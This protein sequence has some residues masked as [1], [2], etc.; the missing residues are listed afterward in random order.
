[1]LL[2]FTASIFD[3]LFIFIVSNSGPVDCDEANTTYWTSDFAID[4]I[5]VH[6]NPKMEFRLR[7]TRSMSS[8][9][10]KNYLNSVFPIAS[11]GESGWIIGHDRLKDPAR[12]C[13]EFVCASSRA[14]LTG[15]S[16][17]RDLD[18]ASRNSNRRP[19]SDS[20]VAKL[21]RVTQ[22]RRC[23]CQCKLAIT[24]NPFSHE[25]DF[26]I[27]RNHLTHRN[28]LNQHPPGDPK[29]TPVIRSLSTTAIDKY[30]GM[31]S[32]L[33][34]QPS[35]VARL[36]ST[37]LGGTVDP[38]AIGRASRSHRSSET[39][40]V[41]EQAVRAIQAEFKKTGDTRNPES[42]L[43]FGFYGDS[44]VS[45][46]IQELRAMTLLDGLRW[47]V[48]LD[49]PSL[50]DLTKLHSLSLTHT[51][52]SPTHVYSSR[53]PMSSENQRVAHQDIPPHFSRNEDPLLAVASHLANASVRHTCPSK[54]ALHNRIIAL[55]HAILHLE[56]KTNQRIDQHCTMVNG[57]IKDITQ[58]LSRMTDTVHGMFAAL[59][60]ANPS[61]PAILG[62]ANPS[63]PTISQHQ[64]AELSKQIKLGLTDLIAELGLRGPASASA[65]NNQSRPSPSSSAS[66]AAQAS[67]QLGTHAPG[68]PSE[69]NPAASQPAISSSQASVQLAMGAP[70]ES[71]QSRLQASSASPAPPASAPPLEPADEEDKIVAL[72]FYDD[73][74]HQF[75]RD[76]S[77]SSIKG[78]LYHVVSLW[79]FGDRQSVPRIR[80]YKLISPQSDLKT[81]SE[82][83]SFSKLSVLMKMVD[84]FLLSKLNITSLNLMQYG[85]EQTT[86]A[87]RFAVDQV[88]IKA[89]QVPD[90]SSLKP[91][92]AS[93]TFTSIYNRMRQKR[94]RPAAEDSLDQEAH[95]DEPGARSDDGIESTHSN[96]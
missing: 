29:S 19:R 79:H 78:D 3:V 93:L 75:P 22:S 33:H 87:V 60:P 24:Q 4:G 89:F 86:Q 21:R 74:W 95:L 71:N 46:L 50:S 94:S 52:S 83:A 15:E 68:A 25:G 65:S 26:Y 61:A 7:G 23:G 58:S 9:E 47:I 88:L 48:D 51:S 67:A 45:L 73:S 35:A 10:L 85:T 63:V 49:A 39:A 91:G 53:C 92:T 20:P 66:Q 2:F 82:R 54:E 12:G 38:K 57:W 31:V 40:H 70:A 44:D 1:V 77:M 59:G 13:I 56:E 72:L 76:F 14:P 18:R 36:A 5:S 84:Q 80:P 96:Q 8:Q 27:Y 30:G 41:R 55:E 11:P 64:F 37:E 42:I 90:V 62:P 69:S 17:T 16:R 32:V 34:A 81:Q 28:P 6:L 43:S